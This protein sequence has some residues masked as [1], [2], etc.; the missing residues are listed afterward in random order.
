MKSANAYKVTMKEIAD[1]AGMSVM[2]VSR[3]L[4][5]KEC[6]SDKTKEK[7]TKIAKKCGY[8]PNMLG[9]SLVMNRFNTIVVVI[10]NIVHAFFPII[11]NAIED[12]LSPYG[13]NTFLCCSHDNPEIEA[14]KVRTLLEYRVAGIIMMPSLRSE[15]SKKTAELVLN[16]GVPLMLVDRTIKGIKTDTI[17]WESENAIEEIVDDLYKKGCRKFVY[18]CGDKS[19][20]KSRGRTRGFIE[21]LKR[22]KLSPQA[23]LFCPQKGDIET[24]LKNFCRNAKNRPDA[25]CCAADTFIDETLSALNDLNISV[26]QDAAL[27]G[28]GGIINSVN[29][30]IKITTVKQDADLMGSEA[31]RIIMK[32]VLGNA[33][34]ELPKQFVK[35]TIPLKVEHN[36]SS[37]YR[38]NV[39]RKHLA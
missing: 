38:P 6:C 35:M 3:V 27:T 10:P 5:G 31:A 17:S 28:F 30:R 20:W 9:R 39:R 14:K 21:S 23:M 32:R 19:E 25:F 22:R 34:A 1:M 2:T 7:I 8:V 4:A 24:S 29:S 18:I 33:P 15:L 13:F 11:V 16:S 36:E 37:D 26:P 12:A